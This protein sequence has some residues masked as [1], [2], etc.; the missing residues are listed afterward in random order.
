M[1]IEINSGDAEWF[2]SMGVD[3]QIMAKFLREVLSGASFE[4]NDAIKAVLATWPEFFQM[5]KIEGAK[6]L[7]KKVWLKDKKI[8]TNGGM[9][10][11]LDITTIQEVD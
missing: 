1:S 4:N 11:D 9:G 2:E 5:N 3:H 6:D 10:L 8:V 7:F